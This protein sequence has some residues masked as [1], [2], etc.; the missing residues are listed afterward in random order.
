MLLKLCLSTV[1]MVMMCLMGCTFASKTDMTANTVRQNPAEQSALL[2]VELGLGYLAQEQHARAKAK[3]VHALALAPR[4]PETQGAM[5]YFKEVVGDYEDAERLHLKAIKVAVHK[6]AVCNNYGAYLCR[7]GKYAAADFAF[8]QALQD[9][10]YPRTAEVFEN[11]GLCMLK[12]ATSLDRLSVLKA[13]H[14][15]T[16]AVRHDPKR[17]QARCA[18]ET[19]QKQKGNVS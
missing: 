11:A 12:S 6:G 5:A 19:L 10:D 4:L 2:N 3:L 16:Q 13:E 1:C 8:Q 7:Q 17:E 18:L 9:T 14:Y 15:L